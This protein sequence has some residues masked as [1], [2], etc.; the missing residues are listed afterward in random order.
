MS[1]PTI[2]EARELMRLSMPPFEQFLEHCA[3]LKAE[4]EKANDLTPEKATLFD[5][6]RD[7][8][9]AARGDY[10]DQIAG[11]ICEHFAAEEVSA[12]IDF[13]TGP[14]FKIVEKALGL[15]AIVANIG[16]TWRTKVLEQCPDVWKMLIENVAQWQARNLPEGST[17]K[18]PA[19]PNE[20]EGWARLDDQPQPAEE[21]I[22]VAPEEEAELERMRNADS[23]S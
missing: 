16:T 8:L 6:Y 3:E 14:V 18:T 15:G 4:C 20:A 11:V 2:T 21:F 1:K 7:A 13:Y 23:T 5:Q 12:L 17:V 9:I 22:P 19:S 10:E